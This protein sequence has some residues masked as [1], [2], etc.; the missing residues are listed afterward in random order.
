MK[1]QITSALVL[2]SALLSIT[3]AAH[4]QGGVADNFASSNPQ[5][6]KADNLT[7][8]LTVLNA[9]GPTDGDG[10]DSE[11]VS[12][13]QNGSD[14]N[15]KCNDADLNSESGC[16]IVIM[17][18]TVSLSNVVIS[19]GK[20]LVIQGCDDGIEIYQEDVKYIKSAILD[21][22]GSTHIINTGRNCLVNLRYINK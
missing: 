15:F 19:E 14:D 10:L 7:S 16:D 3:T 4:A 22:S 13:Y 5:V 8:L 17:P 11:E 12:S 9:Q 18:M 21:N 2:V 6:T 20:R 1:K